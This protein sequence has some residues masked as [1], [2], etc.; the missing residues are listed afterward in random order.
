MKLS[1]LQKRITSGEW[2]V[3]IGEGQT[4]IESPMFTVAENL[5]N[6]DAAYLAHCANHL[7][8]VLEALKATCFVLDTVMGDLA[9]EH[10]ELLPKFNSKMGR[11]MMAREILAAAEEVEGI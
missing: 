10:P 6:D 9:K 5:T 7:P 1:E 8:K 4:D 11:A 3:E 2:R